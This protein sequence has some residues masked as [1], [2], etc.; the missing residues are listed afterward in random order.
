MSLTGEFDVRENK[1]DIYR[2]GFHEEVLR[3][4]KRARNENN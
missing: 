4:L 2:V 3:I 1:C